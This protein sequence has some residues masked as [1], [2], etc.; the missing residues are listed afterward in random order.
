MYLA[1]LILSSRK[2]F[3]LHFG[4]LA[5]N[6]RRVLHLERFIGIIHFFYQFRCD[7]FFVIY[8]SVLFMEIHKHGFYC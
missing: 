3:S 1:A 5:T 6:D 2:F 8:H 4:L 7:E